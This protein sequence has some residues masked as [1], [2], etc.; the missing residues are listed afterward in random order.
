MIRRYRRGDAKKVFVQREQI[1][2]KK[3]AVKFFDD[4]IAYS[5]VNERDKVL[6]VFGFREVENGAECY[7]LL[8]E[9]MEGKMLEF[10]RF[11]DKKIKTEASKRGI[12]NI[13]ITVKDGFYN[14]KRMAKM[15]NFYEV[16]KL[17]LFFSNQDYWLFMRKE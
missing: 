16:V 2:E 15:L 3:E 12:E 1:G 11:V 7:S 5:L 14:A 13:L 8:G 6:A 10:I 4:I 9:D 17:P